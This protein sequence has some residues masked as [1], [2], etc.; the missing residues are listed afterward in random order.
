MSL[1][2]LSIA[3]AGFIGGGA[4]GVAL[5]GFITSGEVVVSIRS[6]CFSVALVGVAAFAS[7]MISVCYEDSAAFV[8]GFESLGVEMAIYAESLDA[9]SS[10]ATSEGEVTRYEVVIEDC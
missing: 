8:T 5:D 3:T 6:T 1:D 9:T 4:L 7:H 10:Y 2:P